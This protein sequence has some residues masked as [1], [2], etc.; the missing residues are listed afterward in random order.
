M[1]VTEISREA[2][3]SHMTF[4]RHFPTKESVVVDDLFDPLIAQAVAAQP[5]ALPPLHRVVRGL[6]AA[7]DGEDAHSELASDEFVRRVTLAASTPSLRHAVHGATVA[8][9]DAIVEVLQD[10]G[11]DTPAARAAAA[12][13]LG[14]A[15]ALLLEW[16]RTAPARKGT[17]VEGAADLLRRGLLGLLDEAEL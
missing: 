8:T 15:T 3:V 9:E 12:A 10:G 14:A 4:F 6:V 11:T 13:V 5:A 1:A 7:M 2:G 16:A 17:P